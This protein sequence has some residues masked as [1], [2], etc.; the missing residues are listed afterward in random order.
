VNGVKGEKEG[1]KKKQEPSGN[2]RKRPAEG[3]WGFEKGPQVVR[4]EEKVDTQKKKGDPK[5]TG[6][7]RGVKG[8]GGSKQME[9]RRKRVTDRTKKKRKGKKIRGIPNK[10]AG[11]K[12]KRFQA[13][14]G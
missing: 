13:E 2:K 10:V 6:S 12:K 14:M 7:H 9:K 8:G 11:T 4:Q 5:Q 1:K 3:I